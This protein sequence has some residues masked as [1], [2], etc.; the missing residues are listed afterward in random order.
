M[1]ACGH[2]KRNRGGETKG[3]NQDWGGQR[4]TIVPVNCPPPPKKRSCGALVKGDKIAR[5]KEKLMTSVIAV[6]IAIVGGIFALVI[7]PFIEILF[8]L[9]GM[10]LSGYHSD[11]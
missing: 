9:L 5:M 6:A 2:C 11:L 10:I 7:L 3:G 4:L 8:A 1:F